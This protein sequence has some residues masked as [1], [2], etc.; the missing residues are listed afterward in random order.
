MLNEVSLAESVIV[1]LVIH[2]TQHEYVYSK[3]SAHLHD[4]NPLADLLFEMAC[5]CL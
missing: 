5:G 3:G 1:P 4:L 2:N